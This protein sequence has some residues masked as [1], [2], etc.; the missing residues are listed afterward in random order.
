MAFSEFT[1][2]TQ[3]QSKLLPSLPKWPSW[4]KANKKRS[5]VSSGDGSE[6]KRRCS[7]RSKVAGIFI[8]GAT[9]ALIRESFPNQKGVVVSETARMP[10]DLLDISL[11]EVVFAVDWEPAVKE[12]LSDNPSPAVDKSAENIVEPVLDL[13]PEKEKPPT[14]SRSRCLRSSAPGRVKRKPTKKFRIRTQ[15]RIEGGTYWSDKSA[16]ESIED[17]M[18]TLRT[19]SGRN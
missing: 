14:A 10:E 16:P 5:R 15:D 11:E 13:E 3:W 4:R 18:F 12:I 17:G 2:R 19:H 7:T 6:P 8:F 9:A 1:E